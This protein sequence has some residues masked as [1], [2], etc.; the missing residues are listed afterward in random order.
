LTR[1]ERTIRLVL[2]LL[3]VAMLAS[4]IHRV[5][6]V[7]AAPVAQDECDEDNEYSTCEYLTVYRPSICIGLTPWTWWWGF[8][9]CE[10]NNNLM[11][12]S[13]SRTEFEDG[14][15]TEIERTHTDGRIT[16]LTRWQRR[17]Q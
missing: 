13:I 16:R 6:G 17:K 8:W 3:A 2:V 12:E 4:I 11:S 9:G 10:N 7:D 5:A 1:T 15:L 14:T